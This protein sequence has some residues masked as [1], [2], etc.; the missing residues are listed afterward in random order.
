MNGDRCA[1]GGPCRRGSMFVIT[2]NAAIPGV[3]RIEPPAHTRPRRA[4]LRT[5]DPATSGKTGGSQQLELGRLAVPPRDPVGDRQDFGLPAGRIDAGQSGLPPIVKPLAIRPPGAAWAS[6]S[7]GRPSAVVRSRPGPGRC[8]C[9][10]DGDQARRELRAAGRRAPR[11]AP[12]FDRGPGG[13]R[14]AARPRA[15]GP[16]RVALPIDR[17]SSGFT[18][19]SAHPRRRRTGSSAGSGRRR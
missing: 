16:R 12:A 7:G 2:V 3:G 19:G 18:R 13:S 6:L 15:R 8:P 9:R 4:L 5:P 11:E 1:R 17:R 10:R 14:A